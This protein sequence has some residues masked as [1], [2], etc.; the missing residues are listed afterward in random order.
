MVE[1]LYD[2]IRAS[3][4]DNVSLGA[5]IPDATGDEDCVLRLYDDERNEFFV[6]DGFFDTENEYWGFTIPSEITSTLHGRYWYCICD[7]GVK[8]QFKQPIYFV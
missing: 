4:G 5:V 8:L 2:A 7:R 3:A 1:Y 6:A